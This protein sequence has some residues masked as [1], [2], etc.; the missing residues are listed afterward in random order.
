MVPGF[1]GRLL[2][3]RG[4]KCPDTKIPERTVSPGSFSLVTIVIS[5]QLSTELIKKP[6]GLSRNGNWNICG[7]IAH[8]VFLPHSR[9]G[10]WEPVLNRTGRKCV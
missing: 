7:F 2:L 9:L 3:T 5:A 8:S 10:L 6:Y 4:R 1:S